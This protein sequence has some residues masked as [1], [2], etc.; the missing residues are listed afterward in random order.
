MN[1]LSR[2]IKELCRR[3]QRECEASTDAIHARLEGGRSR[4][5]D[6]SGD[7][8]RT[9]SSGVIKGSIPLCCKVMICV[10]RAVIPNNVALASLSWRILLRWSHI[11][12]AICHKS[13]ISAVTKRSP[14]IFDCRDERYSCRIP[15]QPECIHPSSVSLAPMVDWRLINNTV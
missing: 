5:S 4:R 6:S 10:F 14:L 8:K 3:R 9:F 1:S 15:S 13:L 2:G 12:H 11:S 7:L